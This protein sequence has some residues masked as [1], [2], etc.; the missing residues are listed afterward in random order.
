MFAMALIV[1]ASRSVRAAEPHVLLDENFRGFR[2]GVWLGVVD[3]H[4]EYHY[5]SETALKG[6]WS[7]STFRSGIPWQRAW[8]VMS[9][10]G[11]RVLARTFDAACQGYSEQIPSRKTTIRRKRD[12]Q[13]GS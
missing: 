2:S 9:H 13:S 10:E 1:L 11:Q 6:Q 7:V 3:A 8:R 4:A 5:L 12:G